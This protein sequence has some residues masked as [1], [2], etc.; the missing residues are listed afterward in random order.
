ML[1]KLIKLI[2]TK[3]NTYKLPPPFLLPFLSPAILIRTG[4][5][6]VY[7]LMTKQ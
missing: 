1:I 4:P 2:N 7:L 5:D 3:K 6:P